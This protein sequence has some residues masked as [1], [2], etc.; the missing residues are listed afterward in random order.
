M[1]MKILRDLIIKKTPRVLLFD[2]TFEAD[3][4]WYLKEQS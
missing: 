4:K 2:T 3:G 1:D